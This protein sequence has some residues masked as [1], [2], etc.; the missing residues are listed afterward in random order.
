MNK[1]FALRPLSCSLLIKLTDGRHVALAMSSQRKAVAVTA[2][3]YVA[4]IG[5]PSAT[6]SSVTSRMV[7][8][9]NAKF[10]L[11]PQRLLTITSVATIEAVSPN[12]DTRDP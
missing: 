5:V 11:F 6:R 9:E 2:T 7:S 1:P 4:L 3:S 10:C 8:F 12:P